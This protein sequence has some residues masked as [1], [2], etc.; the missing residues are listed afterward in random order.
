MPAGPG[1][2][3][4]GGVL[5]VQHTL[6]M[7]R[8]PG[9]AGEFAD[10]VRGQRRIDRAAHLRPTPL[11]VIAGDG[12]QAGS[13]TERRTGDGARVVGGDHQCPGPG[14]DASVDEVVGDRPVPHHVHLRP[15]R[16]LGGRSEFGDFDGCRAGVD[17][18]C[19]L[20]RGGPGRGPLPVGVRQ[21]VGRRR[22]DQ[23]RSGHRDPAKSGGGVHRW[24][25]RA[26]PAAP[27]DRL[28]KPPHP[29]P[30]SSGGPGSKP[31]PPVRAL[32]GPL[33]ASRRSSS[34][35]PATA[36]PPRMPG[37]SVVRSASPGAIE[38]QAETA[39]PVVS[40]ASSI[41]SPE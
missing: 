6:D 1:C 30:V 41:P 18:Q 17:H 27:I 36:R 10:D 5:R 29:A 31:R 38:H 39:G 24:S 28:T 25:A 35:I 20:G 21:S 23:H 34:W 12:V 8:Q 22:G 19:A 11:R 7:N 4:D 13:G 14:R 33:P 32:P 40:I 16:T 3:G 37:T 9:A 2:N 15:P 26:A